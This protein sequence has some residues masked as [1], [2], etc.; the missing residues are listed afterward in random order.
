MLIGRVRFYDESYT[1]GS[2]LC[3]REGENI[4]CSV[5][6]LCPPLAII[7]FC[8]NEGSLC[9]RLSEIGVPCVLLD[10][11]ICEYESCRNKIALLDTSR[12]LVALDPSI[13]T[14]ELY[15]SD[16]SCEALGFSCELGRALDFISCKYGDKWEC[17]CEYEYE[18]EYEY[19][20]E[21]KHKAKSKRGEHLFTSV[22]RICEKGELFEEA[23]LLW[24]RL[25]PD[26]VII[27]VKIPSEGEGDVRL[28]SERVEQIFCAA[29]YGSFS[30]SFSGFYCDDELSSALGLFH[31][32][33]CLLEAEGREFNGYIPRGITISSPMWLFRSSPVTN[34]D[35]LIFDLDLLLPSLFSLSSDEIMKKEK[36]L[37]KELFLVFERYFTHFAPRC[38]VYIKS[39]LFFKTRLLRELARLIEARTIY[40]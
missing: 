22:E 7:I 20:R 31:K 13:D 27:D 16:E 34:P 39:R 28:F 17:G 12:G 38:E 29:L 32:A 15:R 23:L 21:Y 11:R 35:F 6:S 25:S 24:E 33:F 26:S 40:R 9:R 3:V 5:L 4:D 2:I 36:A 18:Y 14:L 30:I 19:E 1:E 37:K 10:C 8:G